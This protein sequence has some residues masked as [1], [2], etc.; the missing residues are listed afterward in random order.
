MRRRSAAGFTLI[1]LLVVIA[2]I[3]ILASLLTPAVSQAKARARQL[4]CLNHLKQIG[5]ATLM[6]AE[7]HR[8]RFQLRFPL[9]ASTTWASLLSTNQGLRPFEIF[10]CPSYL[11]LARADWAPT[12]FALTGQ[13]NYLRV[14]SAS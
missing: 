8:G 10:L 9:A 4:Q 7:D 11:P 6:Y 3:G 12:A 14:T 2:I 13:V 1:E 5:V